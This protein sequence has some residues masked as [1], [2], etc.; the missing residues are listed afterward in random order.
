MNGL[1][2][3]SLKNPYAVTVVVLTIVVFGVISVRIDP[4]RHPAGVQEPGRASADVLSRHAGRQHGTIITYPHGAL[5]GPGGRHGRQESRSIVG[6]SIVRNYYRS[7]IDPNGALT[8]VNSLASAAIP[9][10][11][12][13]TLAAGHLAV[14]SRPARFPS[15]IVASTARRRP[16]RSCTTSARYEVRNMIMAI[17]GAVAPVVYGG[18]IRAVLAYLDRAKLQARDLSPLDVMNALDNYNIF[19]PTGDA[20]FGDTDY[21]IDSNSMYDL[22]ERMGDIPIT[23]RAR[24]RHVPARRGHAEGREFHPDQRRP[25]QR[26]PPGLHSRLPAA[27]RQHAERGRWA[28]G[29][30]CPT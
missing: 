10:L 17:P 2:K 7:D 22:V 27:R 15:C 8:Q 11:P 18:K 4:H 1:I 14:R 6:A 28:Q 21:A 9:N 23:H 30:R 26:P 20:K 12:P 5:D 19:L 24:Q 25:R 3:A 13:G 16:K 29:S